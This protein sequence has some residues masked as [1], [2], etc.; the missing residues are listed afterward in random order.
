MLPPML[1]GKVIMALM[2]AMVVPIVWLWSK[3]IDYKDGVDRKLHITANVQY[4]EKALN[5]AL[6]PELKRITLTEPDE[7]MSTAVYLFWMEEEQSPVYLY[8][9]MEGE[10]EVRLYNEQ[11]ASAEDDFTVT[12]P[13]QIID[14][15]PPVSA[16]DKANL[17]TLLSIM[18]A[19]KPAGRNY[20]I[21]IDETGKVVNQRPIPQE[22]V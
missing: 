22:P 4:I 13:W 5:D 2:S 19:Y 15:I 8:K 12:V 3:F 14:E 10:E 20:K 1:R 11:E 17:R 16:L 6:D 18:E 21:E 9:S 7:S